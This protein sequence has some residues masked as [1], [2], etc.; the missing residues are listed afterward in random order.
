[1]S[2]TPTLA[3]LI[4]SPS[5]IRL[6]DEKLQELGFG[7][8]SAEVRTDLLDFLRPKLEMAVGERLADG[9]TSREISDFEAIVDS[10]NSSAALTY[11]DQV[12]PE[13]PAIVR[14]EVERLVGQLEAERPAF[15]A[16]FRATEEGA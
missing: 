7:D 13:H 8:L 3:P 9:M 11:L 5:T 16:A 4:P 12:C 10:E 6:D 14:E 2:S 15:L 1:M